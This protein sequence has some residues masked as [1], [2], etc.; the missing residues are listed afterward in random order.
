MAGFRCFETMPQARLRSW[1]LPCLMIKLLHGSCRAFSNRTC[2]VLHQTLWSSSQRWHTREERAKSTA[3]TSPHCSVY[4]ASGSQQQ[5]HNQTKKVQS[6]SLFVCPPKTDF[7]HQPT[8][9]VSLP[10][11]HDDILISSKVYTVMWL[12]QCH[13]VCH[14]LLLPSLSV[15]KEASTCI[16]YMPG[17][18]NHPRVRR[19]PEKF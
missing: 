4:S 6:L 5:S 12:S 10:K 17:T 3:Q 14:L 19:V 2:T 16:H 8:N 1:T 18:V 15:A 7:F 9:M 11:F 13:H